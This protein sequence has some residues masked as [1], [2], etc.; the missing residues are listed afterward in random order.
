MKKIIFWA[1]GFAIV[2]QVIRPDYTNQP[3]DKNITL[4][5][6]SQV[7]NVLKTSCYD[8]HSNETQYLW[9]HNVAPVS[10]VLSSNIENGRKALNFSN[11]K[12]IDPKVKLERLERAKKV[13]NNNMMP[14]SEYVLMHENAAL[15]ADEKRLLEAFFDAQIKELSVL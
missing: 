9:Y 8:C 4:D 15:G 3:I 1:V 10:W 5:T 6:D 13:V 2:I 12:N 14:K 7:M 11:W